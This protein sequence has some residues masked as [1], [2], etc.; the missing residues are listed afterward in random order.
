MY[1]V[2]AQHEH[3]SVDAFFGVVGTA[4]LF[5]ERVRLKG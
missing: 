4:I 5:T 2:I 3:T 1:N